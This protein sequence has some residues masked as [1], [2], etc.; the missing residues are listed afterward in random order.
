MF[1]T[2]CCVISVCTSFVATELAAVAMG[3]Y[4]GRCLKAEE[5]HVAK[6]SLLVAHCW[7][8]SGPAVKRTM[9]IAIRIYST[10]C[11]SSAHGA[12]ASSRLMCRHA[13]TFNKL[14]A[15]NDVLSK[16]VELHSKSNMKI[17]LSALAVAN[18]FLICPNI[19]STCECTYLVQNRLSMC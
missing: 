19:M 1:Y 9:D 12:K 3:V 8:T 2:S 18:R 17:S 10:L 16:Q 6:D 14:F 4:G 7:P 13:I 11:A 15:L 5:K